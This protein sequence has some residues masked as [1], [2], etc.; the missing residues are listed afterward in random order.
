MRLAWYDARRGLDQTRDGKECD[1]EGTPLRIECKK[2]ARNV[3][4]AEAIEQARRDAARH[5]DSRPVAAVTAVDYEEPW[6]TM[7]LTDFLAFVTA[8]LQRDVSGDEE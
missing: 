3:N 5:L 4:I 6:I 2:R 8:S 1:V 7:P